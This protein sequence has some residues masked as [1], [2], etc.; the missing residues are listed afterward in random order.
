MGGKSFTMQAL[1]QAPKLEAYVVKTSVTGSV[2]IA[3]A[4]VRDQETFFPT[5]EYVSFVSRVP[6]EGEIRFL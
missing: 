6:S 4:M 5:H 3:D 1:S 2:H